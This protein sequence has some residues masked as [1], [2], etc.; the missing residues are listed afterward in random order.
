MV[1]LILRSGSQASPNGFPSADV[2]PFAQCVLGGAAL[3]VR[4]N[5]CMHVT[6]RSYFPSLQII[7]RAV[8]DEIKLGGV[9]GGGNFPRHVYKYVYVV[10][11]ARLQAAPPR[12][13]WQTPHF[14]CSH[15]KL[16]RP[17]R[18]GARRGVRRGPVPVPDPRTAR[19]R[20][21]L[22]KR[23]PSSGHQRWEVGA[24]Q[25]ARGDWRSDGSS[26]GSLS[27]VGTLFCPPVFCRLQGCVWRTAGGSAAWP[28]TAQEWNTARRRSSRFQVHTLQPSLTTNSSWNLSHSRPLFCH[29]CI[30][31]LSSDNI[32]KIFQ[33]YCL[34]AWSGR[35]SISS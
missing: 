35:Y 12:N 10:L 2:G 11:A 15:G 16:P 24:D 18:V 33:A 28:T 9:G 17:A 3:I 25:L 31:L 4:V 5:E 19:A 8:K 6:L 34:S 27:L 20:H 30:L 26:P 32:P 1:P 22:G 13:D 21:Q 23:Q 7:D 29:K 14:L